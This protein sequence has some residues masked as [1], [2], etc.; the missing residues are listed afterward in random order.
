MQLVGLKVLHEFMKQHLDIQG[1]LETWIQEVREASWKT[2]LEIKARYASAS[3]LSDN[4]VI[5]NVKGNKYRLLVKVGFNLQT[6]LIQ[7]IGTHAEYDKW[8]L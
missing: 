2:T 5:F 3:F 4:R 7:R 8:D 6:V 1:P